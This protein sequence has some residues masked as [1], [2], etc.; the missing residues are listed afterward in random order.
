MMQN[1]PTGWE[2]VSRTEVISNNESPDFVKK[3]RVLY[4]FE[5]VQTMKIIVVHIDNQ[6]MDPKTVPVNS[7]VSEWSHF[8]LTPFLNLSSLYP[9]VVPS[10]TSNSLHP[11]FLPPLLLMP[12]R[13]TWEKLS[14]TSQTCSPLT[15]A[16]SP[17]TCATPHASPL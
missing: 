17:S 13:R 2:E 15:A 14:S 12:F 10:T 5:A 3:F 9:Q 4:N 11:P 6:Q 16:S 8:T 7:C 1:M